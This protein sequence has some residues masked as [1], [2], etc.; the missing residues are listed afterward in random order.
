MFE[1]I[2]SSH[3]DD[4]KSEAAQKR[5]REHAIRTGLRAKKEKCALEA[6]KGTRNQSPAGQLSQ[7]QMQAKQSPGR[8]PYS[9]SLVDPFQSLCERPDR[10]AALLRNR[11]S[12]SFYSS[13]STDVSSTDI[14][15][16]RACIQS[17][18][19]RHDSLSRH[20]STRTRS[21]G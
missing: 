14:S 3:P 16:W 18:R 8:L 9:V 19:W 6:E 10:L 1:F 13:R 17:H 15:S 2:T 21:L 5:I 12:R 20:G 11:K 4:S 7:L